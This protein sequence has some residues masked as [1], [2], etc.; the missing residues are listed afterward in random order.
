VVTSTAAGV[1]DGFG[2]G[3]ATARPTRARA[4]GRFARDMEDPPA[5]VAPPRVSVVI[6]TL[7]EA[8]NLPHVFA[9][10][11]PD[12]FE[13]IVVDGRSSDG[14]AAVA[15]E[16]RSDVRVLLETRPGKG[17]ALARGFAAARGDI[18]VTLD[19]DGSADP[20]EIPAFVKALVQ[21]ADFAKGSRHLPGAGSAD[22]TRVRSLGNQCLG[23]LVNRLFGTRYTDLC[24]GYNAFWRGALDSIAV[25][26]DGFEV[27]TLIN[28]R[29]ARA[30]L[31]VSEVASYEH[32]RIHGASNLRAVRDGTRVLRT[33]LKERARRS[34][35]GVPDLA[36][37]G[38]DAERRMAEIN[39]AYELLRATAWNAIHPPPRT[40]AAPRPVPTRPGGWLSPAIRRALGPELLRA[41]EP[42][43]DVWLVTPTT[44]WASPE[45]LLS[46]TDRRLLWLLDDSIGDRVHVLRFSAIA[47]AA[48]ALRRPRRRVAT[49]R[50]RARNGRRFSFGE[51][52]PGTAALLVDRIAE[53]GRRTQ[54]Q[55]A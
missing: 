1:N 30:G 13:V 39:G 50:V 51:L 4:A 34:P 7:N 52:R 10:L 27:E 44:T 11:P 43:E 55:P 20:R 19:A 31:V 16:L 32:Q 6:P 29:V 48:L 49:L 22:L 14:T 47:E 28:I 26:C 12:L 53:G 9:A 33:I 37:G 2:V 15:Q 41:L 8:A 54:R 38:A 23:W 5:N 42:G 25:D 18:V 36:G 45:A 17:S 46:A 21:G 40:P 3:P 24:Y 35:I